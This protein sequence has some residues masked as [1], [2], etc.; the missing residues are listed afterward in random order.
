MRLSSSWASPI[1]GLKLPCVQ[2]GRRQSLKPSPMAARTA[3]MVD[4]FVEHSSLMKEL[5]HEYQKKEDFDNI[6]LV[7]ALLQETARIAHSKET[8]IQNLI[9]GTWVQGLGV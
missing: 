6:A 2:T 1:G 5:Y 9:S 4:P 7:E 3:R 8:Q